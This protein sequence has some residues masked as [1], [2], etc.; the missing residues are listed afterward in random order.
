MFI[1]ETT[2][3]TASLCQLRI[4]D[5]S[6][7]IR[8]EYPD[9][10]GAIVL[11]GAFEHD[12]YKFRQESSFYYLTGITE[13]GAVVVIDLQGKSTLYI[14]DHGANR[15]AWVHTPVSLTQENAKKLGFEHIK[16]LGQMAPGYQF[17]PFS[18]KKHYS[19]LL[20]DLNAIIQAD[21]K[22][23]TLMPQNSWEYIEQRS[24]LTRFDA[25]IPGFQNHCVDIA[26][27]VAALR[28]KKDMREIETMYKAVEITML[29][30]E[31]AAHAIQDG[32]LECE[33]QA[34]LEY[35]FTGSN[36]YPSFPSIVAGGKNGT[37]LHYQT[38]AD[39]LKNGQLV[40]VDIGAE[41]EYYCADLTRTYPVSGTFTKRQKELYNLVL[42]TQ[43][44]IADL[45]KPGMWLSN[46]DKPEK[47]LN[48]LAKKF[49]DE[50]GYGNYFPHGIGHFL[51]ID[52]HD[53]GDLN[54]PLKEGDVFT[55]EPGI[56]I[57]QEGI[58]IRIE[59]NYWVVKDG[60]VCLSESLPKKPED[61]EALMQNDTDEADEEPE[62]HSFNDV[63]E[64]SEEFN[65]A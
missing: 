57:P 62:E 14:P 3:T 6:A 47:S 9:Q 32:I 53:V 52:V 54:E 5:L 45:A 64:E 41:Y 63:E 31:A 38:N 28:R 26:P 4:K 21:G 37:I 15:A 7:L 20:A 22:I 40:V 25:M 60:V 30:Q 8:Q 1:N 13:P 24:M 29:A 2:Q 44:Y 27:L 36:A 35:M 12:R 34:S 46:K 23:F 65:M 18:D 43:E 42:A 33:V 51:G 59:D 10:K 19:N 56:Y 49:L 55:I 58:G 61:I 17:H 16:S 11:F 48:H 39:V 50:R